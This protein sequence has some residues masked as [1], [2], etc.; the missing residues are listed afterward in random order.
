MSESREIGV[1][2]G[3]GGV[4]VYSSSASHGVR[5]CLKCGADGMYG[6]PSPTLLSKE[7]SEQTILRLNR[8][9]GSLAQAARNYLLV[10]D[11][12][13]RGTLLRLANRALGR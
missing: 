13:S 5:R 3:C 1:H 10:P 12:D 9:I 8:E 11:E 4:V 6:R 2:A 7:T